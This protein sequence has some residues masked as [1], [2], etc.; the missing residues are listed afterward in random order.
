MRHL[1]LCLT[2]IA[3][4]APTVA[5]ATWTLDEERSHL[6]FISIKS[7]NIAEIHTFQQM[8]GTIDDDGQ[9]TVTL[10]L[11]SVETLIPIRNE[12]MREFLFETTE[13]KEAVLRAKVDTQMVTGLS[14]GETTV[15]AAEG[16]LSLHGE[17]QAMSVLMRAAKLANDTVMVASVKPLIV[18]ATKFG[19]DDGIEKLREIAGLPS[20]STAVP[21]SFVMTFVDE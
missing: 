18:D 16:T 14:V 20:I 6:T 1:E 4:L 19:L 7:K 2:L 9:A 3:A 15:V 11:D 5:H 13:F 21:V 8:S 10:D 12:R 17:G